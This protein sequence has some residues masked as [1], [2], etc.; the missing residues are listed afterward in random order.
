MRKGLRE[1]WWWG[2]L[3]FFVRAARAFPHLRPANESF[4][5]KR[6]AF[7][8]PILGLMLIVS[9]HFFWSQ[10]PTTEMLRDARHDTE[11]NKA[12]IANGFVSQ[13]TFFRCVPIRYDHRM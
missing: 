9:V 10:G 6:W 2:S 8:N 13:S 7:S 1:F 12:G 5:A 4:D 11:G 3:V